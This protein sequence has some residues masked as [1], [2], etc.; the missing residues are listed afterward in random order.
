MN[1]GAKAACGE[2]IWFLHVDLRLPA[3]A[4]R[5]IETTLSESSCVGGCFRL[6]FPKRELIYRISDSCG[7]LGVEVFG[8]ALGDHG[9]FCRRASF[10]EVGGYPE[11]PILEDAEIYRRLHRRRMVQMRRRSCA[12]RGPM[13]ADCIERR[14]STSSF[15]S[16]MSSGSDREFYRIYRRFRRVKGNESAGGM[17]AVTSVTRNVCPLR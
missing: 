15:S 8:F 7:N 12:T 2:V 9:I 3:N 17:A 14:S 5:L 13:S 6:R 16:S 11:V 1:A 4:R 10:L